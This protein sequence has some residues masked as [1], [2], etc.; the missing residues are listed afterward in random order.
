MRRLDPGEVVAVGLVGAAL[1]ADVVLIRRD[2]LPISTCVR[3]GVVA[4]V[5]A[6]YL[7]AHLLFDLPPWIHEKTRHDNWRGG[8]WDRLLNAR[9]AP[10]HHGEEH[11]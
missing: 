5:V 8:P 6:A 9:A 7:A 11:F 3:R 10:A 1:T 2:C 4:R